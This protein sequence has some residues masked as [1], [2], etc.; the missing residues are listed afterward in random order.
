MPRHT[1]VFTP[2]EFPTHTY[3]DRSKHRFEEQL[4]EALQIPNIVVSISGPSKSGK[5]VL[6]RKVISADDLIVINGASIRSPSD[7]WDGVLSWMES[8][9]E[10][11][12]TDSSANELKVEG[13]AGGEAGIPLVAKGKAEAGLGLNV[14]GGSEERRVFKG[15]GIA[16]VRKEIGG[17][18][19]VVFIDDFHYIDRQMQAEIGR[20]VKA[21]AEQG[22]R[23]CVAS[24]PHRA[25][26]V[27]R[28]NPE[29]HGRIKAIDLQY[30]DQS[31]LEQIGKKGFAALYYNI[32]EEE[33]NRLSSEAFGSPQLMQNLCLNYCFEAK[34]EN[35]KSGI[36]N[37]QAD[38]VRLQ[39]V[40]ERASTYSDFSSL[41]EALHA[42]PKQRGQE[43]NK[44]Q[45][46]DQTRGDVYRAILLAVKENPGR[47][48]FNYDQMLQRVRSICS[49]DSPSGS[50]ISQA[51]SQMNEKAKEMMPDRKIIEW[52]EDN[53]DIVDP[54]F[55]FFIRNSSKLAALA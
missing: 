18:S 35:E 50:S 45:L 2:Y 5:T 28:S 32:L 41:V 42:G 55:L 23:I 38:F 16:Q 40:L 34:I 27:F 54:Y 48:S 30:W 6:L 49:A 14:R 7:L 26:D 51:L 4:R 1:E 46:K 47:L 12:E 15:G 25:D 22:I 24:V 43:R 53:L 11:S 19:F 21:A 10:W 39:R 44:Y 37:V 31:D 36:V 3:V 8:P 33:I 13:K 20:Q 52:D 29:L 9:T 17:S